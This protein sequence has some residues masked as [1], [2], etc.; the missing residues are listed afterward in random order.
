MPKYAKDVIKADIMTANNVEKDCISD[1]DAEAQAELRVK[2]PYTKGMRDGMGIFVCLGPCY[3]AGY[4]A[5]VNDLEYYKEPIPFD[6]VK[7][8]VHMIHGV[9]DD[10]IPYT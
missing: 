7:V 4:D 3:P 10:D 9:C 5:M 6:Q 2:D 8:P 1:K